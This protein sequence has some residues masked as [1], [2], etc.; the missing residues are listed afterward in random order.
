MPHLPAIQQR[1]LV[2]N[3][4][5]IIAEVGLKHIDVSLNLVLLIVVRLQLRAVVFRVY[6]VWIIFDGFIT[7]VVNLYY[8]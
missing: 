7:F 8:I 5:I 4:L 6:T 1:L 3:I 2:F